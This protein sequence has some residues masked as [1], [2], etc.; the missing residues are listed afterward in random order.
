MELFSA[1]LYADTWS[2]SH[3]PYGLTQKSQESAHPGKVVCDWSMSST[4]HEHHVTSVQE[5][6]R[7]ALVEEVGL[8]PSW[9]SR[10]EGNC[11][12]AGEA[13]ENR[14]GQAG[15]KKHGRRWAGADVPRDE[16]LD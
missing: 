11:L 8:P 9:T 1:K 15:W 2:L 16:G 5:K 6:S 4:D 12:W 7:G 10:G 3:Q 13:W 14:N